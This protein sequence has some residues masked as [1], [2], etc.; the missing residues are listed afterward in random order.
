MS[1][2][3]SLLF[4][5]VLLLVSWH[6]ALVPV[7]VEVLDGSHVEL[8]LDLLVDLGKLFL[9]EQLEERPGSVEGVEDGSVFVVT[10]VNEFL[11]VSVVELQVQLVLLGQGLLTDDGLHC[12]SVLTLGVQGVHLVGDVGVIL[13]G[14]AITDGSLHES[15]QGGQDVDGRVDASLVHVSVNVDLTLSDV[16]SKI[17]DGVS[18]VVVRHCQDGDLGDG[19]ELA[20]DSTGSLVDGRQIGV[21][22]TGVSSSSWHLLSGGG[23]L[24][25]G[26]GVRGHIGENGQHV[27]LLLVSEMLGGGQSQSGGDD[28]LDGGVVSVIHEEHDSVHGAVD[29]EVGSEESSDLHVDSH[30]G[31]H[32]GEVFVG[33]IKDVL[34]LD[35][36]GL[37]A[38]LGS[39]LVMRESGSGEEGDLLSSG[40]GGHGIDGGDTSLD[41]LLG[42]NSLVRVNWLTL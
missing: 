22:V 18:D 17:W 30:S 34:A 33:V 32:N 23:D 9:L 2:G 7:L 10:L 21:H 8:V 6:L 36:R 16:S 20:L 35:E 25:Q 4:L 42:V 12:L 40:D 28:T 5:V 19:T 41:H 39:D 3:C 38:D 15:R 11:L 26:V 24:S 1:R 31:E 37:S 29:L 14:H 13:S 27:H